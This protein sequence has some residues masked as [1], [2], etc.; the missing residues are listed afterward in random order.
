MHHLRFNGHKERQL[1]QNWEHGIALPF[2]KYLVSMSFED[3][4]TP[5]VW[6]DTTLSQIAELG[7]S[8]LWSTLLRYGASIHG[9][10]KVPI[11]SMLYNAACGGSTSILTSIL[12]S[13]ISVDLSA[14]GPDNTETPLHVA[15]RRGHVAVV[16]LLLDRGAPIAA[17]DAD[18]RTALRI[19]L[20]SIYCIDAASAVQ[21]NLLLLELL[22][23]RG[24]DINAW[25]ATPLFEAVWWFGFHPRVRGELFRCCSRIVGIRSMTY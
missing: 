2:V 19:A 22:I 3:F 10:G 14:F 4:D 13:G 25:G 5:D 6:R 23:A 8:K 17:K 11:S 12:T 7:A 24:A 16:K 1:V 18:G 15:V 21:E 20:Y 9:P